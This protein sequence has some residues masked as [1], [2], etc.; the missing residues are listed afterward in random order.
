M[1]ASLWDVL[2]LLNNQRVDGLVCSAGLRSQS[3]SPE[4]GCSSRP[5]HMPWEPRRSP[6]P[7][8]PPRSSRSNRPS[9][10]RVLAPPPLVR[11]WFSGALLV[12]CVLKLLYR[13]GPADPRASRSL[14]LPRWLTS[15]KTDM[16]CSGISSVP[17]L[18]YPA[19]VGRCDLSEAA[20]ASEER[21]DR[22]G[23]A[24]FYRAP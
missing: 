3:G 9:S 14:H 19:W 23:A 7:P 6:H 10:G 8:P 4:P 15:N 2:R 22:H 5:A 18:K 17:E 12:N 1:S 16:D 13:A 20:T 11:P 21:W 24:R